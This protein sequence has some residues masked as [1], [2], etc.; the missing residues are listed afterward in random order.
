MF[1][2]RLV[3]LS[4]VFSMGELLML[5]SGTRVKS[6]IHRRVNEGVVS[7]SMMW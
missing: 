5:V 2:K 1:L 6:V 4:V 7:T 3:F